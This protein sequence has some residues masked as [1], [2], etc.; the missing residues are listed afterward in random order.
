MPPVVFVE[1]LSPCDDA[2]CDTDFTTRWVYDFEKTV[3]LICHNDN[4]EEKGLLR[5][6]MLDP[7][8]GLR[9]LFLSSADDV[10]VVH[11]KRGK[12]KDKLNKLQRNELGE[13]LIS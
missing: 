6:L 2:D 7:G 3:L 8:L 5:V 4:E 11:K 10:V 1:N 12:P 13:I 9:D